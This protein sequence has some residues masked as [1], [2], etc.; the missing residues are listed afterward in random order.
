MAMLNMKLAQVK[1]STGSGYHCPAGQVLAVLPHKQPGKVIVR[2][3][4]GAKHGV[5]T[6]ARGSK[7]RS[8]ELVALGDWK[9]LKQR[10]L[11]LLGAGT[12]GHE[13]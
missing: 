8:H 13:R 3:R 11:A 1:G 2:V 9:K 4:R 12:G 6:W 7:V 10:W 5:G